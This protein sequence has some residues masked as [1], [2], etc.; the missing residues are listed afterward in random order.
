MSC[1]G[2]DLIHVN[3]VKKRWSILWLR[4]NICRE[5]IYSEIN[6][7]RKWDTIKQLSGRKAL[8]AYEISL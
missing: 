7:I 2:R 5:N 6:S 4:D 3:E 8:D 1:H